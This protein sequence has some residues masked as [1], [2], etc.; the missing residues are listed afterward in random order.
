MQKRR[1][2]GIWP[3]SFTH[4]LVS[5][6]KR[7]DFGAH[8]QVCAPAYALLIGCRE[9]SARGHSRRIRCVV[10]RVSNLQIDRRNRLVRG[11]YRQGA[12]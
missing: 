4:L 2:K 8:T 3:S 5:F 1:L 10:V 12:R 11:V 9:C 7:Q 6:A